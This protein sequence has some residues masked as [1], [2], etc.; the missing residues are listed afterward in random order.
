MN[1]CRAL[2]NFIRWSGD[3]YDAD[4]NIHAL[5]EAENIQFND[6]KEE[7]KGSTALTGNT[8]NYIGPIWVV[9]TL[10]DK[11]MHPSISFEF[12]LP[13]KSEAEYVHVYAPMDADRIIS[14]PA[15]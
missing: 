1:S 7:T 3:P 4:I 12:Q 14:D 15:S 5:Y 6:L 8:K 9:A 2:K 10:K 13:P 11:L